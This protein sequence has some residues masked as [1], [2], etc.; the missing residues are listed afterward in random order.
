MP[1][2]KNFKDV[3][4]ISVTQDS[5]KEDKFRKDPC[6]HKFKSMEK[7]IVHLCLNIV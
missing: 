7:L 1:T 3:V 5:E 2:N 6:A 4:P